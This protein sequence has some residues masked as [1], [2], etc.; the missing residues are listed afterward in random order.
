M[1]YTDMTAKLRHIGT[2]PRWNCGI[3]ECALL[4]CAILELRHSGMRHIE[5]ASYWTILASLACAIAD[6]PYWHAP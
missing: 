6:S 1:R 5:P 4:K 2:A 3:L